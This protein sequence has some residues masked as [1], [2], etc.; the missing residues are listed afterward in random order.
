MIMKNLPWLGSFVVVFSLSVAL[1]QEQPRDAE[2]LTRKHNETYLKSLPFED[3]RDFEDARRGFLGTIPDAEIKRADGGVAW[4]MKSY[5]FI[6]ASENAPPTVHPSLWRIARLNN[7]HGLFEVVPDALYQVRGFDIAN[8]TII[9]AEKGII[10]LDTMTS[11]E[12][13]KAALELYFKHRPK[14]PIVAVLITHS[15]IDHYGGVRGV[16]EMAEDPKKVEVIVPEHFLEEAVSEN[17][18]AGNAMARRAMYMYGALLPRS[19]VGQV[20]AGL[21]KT[22][23]FGTPG[24]VPPTR[25]IKESDITD[26]KEYFEL[27]V[28]GI[29]MQFLLVPGTEAPAEFVVY[30]PQFKAFCAAEDAT[31]TMHN[32]YT[33]R[34]AQVRDAVNWWKAIDKCIEFFGGDVEVVFAQHHWPKWGNAEINEYL[35]KQRNVYKFIHDRTLNL[36]NKGYTP[37]EIAETIKLP[38][39][40]ENEWSIRGYYGSLRHN[41]R[42]VYQKYLGWYDSNPSNLNPLPP[43]DAAKKYVE[44]M[45]GSEVILAKAWKDFEA[46]QYRWVAE[47]L[48][49]LVFAEPENREARN[50]LA[51][52]LE[53]L[54]YQ[55]ESGPWRNEYLNGAAELRRIEDPKHPNPAAASPE[56]LVGTPVDMLLEFAGVSLNFE[57]S[58]EKSLIVHWSLPDIDEHFRVSLEDSILVHRKVD[59]FETKCD[60]FVRSDRAAIN[61][62]LLGQSTLEKETATGAIRIEGD[63]AKLKEALTFFD[64]FTADFNI[65]LP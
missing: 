13:A 61:R 10:V 1:G 58:F 54:G 20:D 40:L 60:V 64:T 31:H 36:A 27:D 3:T 30:L 9:E 62:I 6:D 48:H 52:A 19:P 33:L 15:H 8:M 4:S 44:Y 29:N 7:I 2:P 35:R 46:G 43:V 51:D 63:A 14:K 50:L 57:K 38:P 16:L 49:R 18:L 59:K 5:G 34:G 24:L 32:L 55:S 17:I 53:Q 11:A 21:G 22:T 39:S 56:T 28:A 47:V 41:A 12:T 25:E 65:V 42:A 37:G 23:P 45:G 26:G